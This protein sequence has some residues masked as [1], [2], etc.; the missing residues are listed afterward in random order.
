MAGQV[1]PLLVLVLLAVVGL[2][3]AESQPKE[4]TVREVQQVLGFD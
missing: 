3:C 2:A 4:L 1:V